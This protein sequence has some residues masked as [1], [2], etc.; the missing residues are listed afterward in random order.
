M[1]HRT[2]LML[3]LAGA[4]GPRIWSPEE[5]PRAPRAAIQRWKDMRLG[6]FIHWGPGQHPGRRDR[7]VPRR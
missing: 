1:T 7:L 3:P 2:F 6:M 4:A 5:D